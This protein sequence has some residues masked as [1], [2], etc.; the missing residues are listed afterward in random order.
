MPCGLGAPASVTPEPN[1]YIEYLDWTESFKPPE[2]PPAHRLGAARRG[3]S[4]P[5]ACAYFMLYAEADSGAEKRAKTAC[6]A[7]RH[8][9][10]RGFVDVM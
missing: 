9:G 7:W 6:V 8:G 10:Q 1:P 3:A 2:T 5:Y 4:E